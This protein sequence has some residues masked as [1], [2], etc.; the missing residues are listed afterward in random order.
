[1]A[2]NT[3]AQPKPQHSQ[4]VFRPGE[5][6]PGDIL[7]LLLLRGGMDG[8]HT[9]PP[10]ADPQFGGIRRKLTLP[11]PERTGGIIDLD[12]FFGLH[13][14]LAPLAELYRE[15]S[16]AIVHACGSPD[17]TLSHFEAT[18][19]L[20]RG[21]S[22]G[23][24]IGSGW[25][26]RHLK[27]HQTNNRSPM[28]AVAFSQ[29]M[30]AALIGAP[31][32]IALPS[33]SQFRFDLPP[34]WDPNFGDALQ[35][36]YTA[37]GDAASRAGTASLRLVSELKKLRVDQYTPDHGAVYPGDL[38]GRTT[39]EVAQ[40]IRAE[41][42]LEVAVVE[43]GGWDTHLGQ[44]PNMAMLMTSLAGSLQALVRDLGTHMKRVVVV[45][46]SEFGR[47]VAENAAQ[48][49]DHGR[50]TAMFV[51]GGGIRG[52]RVYGQWPGLRRDQLDS[53]GNLQ[54]T[55]D[56]RHVLAE[57]VDRRLMSRQ[58]SQVF[59]GFTPGYLNLAT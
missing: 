9:V 58:L 55:T 5:A 38:L 33:L 3:V 16:L 59:P 32:S 35:D 46:I 49:T 42:G 7:V 50:G 41:V 40:L 31:N 22:D 17:Q 10:H 21:V 27:T 19:T 23:N 34:D 2:L 14:L 28:R 44:V 52:G 48:G 20:E 54:V 8:L 24:S 37:S 57:I 29:I 18:R 43:L 47:R 30:P 4:L 51:L 12:G 25:L 56:Y 15:Q 53:H 45:A 39:S 1:M 13:P 6:P 26:T 11:P 36:L